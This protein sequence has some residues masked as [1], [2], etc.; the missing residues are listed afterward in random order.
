MFFVVVI[1]SSEGFVV[2]IIKIANRNPNIANRNPNIAN[3]NH[4]YDKMTSCT[5]QR[6]GCATLCS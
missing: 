5:K 1:F 3:R 2:S 6:A 4:M